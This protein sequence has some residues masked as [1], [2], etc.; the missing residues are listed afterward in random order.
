M[1]VQTG[2][3]ASGDS[4]SDEGEIDREGVALGIVTWHPA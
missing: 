3:I 1:D 4:V 2:E